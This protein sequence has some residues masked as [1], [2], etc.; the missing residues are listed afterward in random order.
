MLLVGYN[1]LQKHESLGKTIVVLGF[2]TRDAVVV[3]LGKVS[4]FFYSSIYHFMLVS[5][6]TTRW[7]AG[8]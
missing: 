7:L 5:Y 2:I 8:V 6:K 3:S 4:V 1:V